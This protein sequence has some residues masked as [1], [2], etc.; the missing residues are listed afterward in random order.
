MGIIAFAI[1]D[2][3]F[4]KVTSLLCVISTLALSIFIVLLKELAL[5][6]ST[7]AFIPLISILPIAV[8]PCAIA[9]SGKA[10]L[11]LECYLS[12]LFLTLDVASPL[13]SPVILLGR[14]ADKVTLIL[15]SN[16]SFTL[17]IMSISCK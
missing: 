3:L 2:V 8:V 13:E 7:N 14:S 6:A 17:V 10:L 4:S 16:L 9:K 12:C 5:L 15:H 1:I 11:L